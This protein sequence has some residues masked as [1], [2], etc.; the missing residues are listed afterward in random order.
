MLSI[1]KSLSNNFFKYLTGQKCNIMVR[2]K[3]A[4]L[5][6]LHDLCGRKYCMYSW[7]RL[8]CKKLIDSDISDKNKLVIERAKK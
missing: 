7:D 2:V 3:L 1:Q 5:N 4:E 6:L 8:E